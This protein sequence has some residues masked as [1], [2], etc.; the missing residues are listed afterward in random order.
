MARR[1]VLSTPQLAWLLFLIMSQFETL[2]AR[3]LLPSALQ[4]DNISAAWFLVIACFSKRQC[5]RA[6]SATAYAFTFIVD[7]IDM[8][9]G[10][11]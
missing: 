3:V 1:N 10:V 4:R 11:P 6:L 8:Q 7:H 5:K 9:L 2:R